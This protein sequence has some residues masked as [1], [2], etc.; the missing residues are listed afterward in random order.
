M[1]FTAGAGDRAEDEGGRVETADPRPTTAPL[2]HLVRRLHVDLARLAS[3]A[4][5]A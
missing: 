4:C 2:V 3:A 1:E 5:R